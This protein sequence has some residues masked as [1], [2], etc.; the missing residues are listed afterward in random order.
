MKLSFTTLA[1]PNWDLDQILAAA[2]QYG[3][4]AIDFRHYKGSTA[5]ATLPEFTTGLS[6]TAKKIAAAGIRVSGISSGIHVFN[7]DAAKR[8]Q[9]VNEA[10][11]CVRIAAGLGAPLVRVFGG[12]LGPTPRPEA[13]KLGGAT[14]RA[15]A[16]AAAR[17]G[18][19]IA[20]ETHDDWVRGAEVMGILHAANA[21]ASAGVLWDVLNSFQDANEPPEVTLHQIKGHLVGTHWKDSSTLHPAP[22][23]YCLPGHGRAPLRKIHELIRANGYD[24]YYTFEWE[25]AW[26]PELAEADIALPEFVKTMR[27]IEAGK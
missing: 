25:K 7:A 10:I 22:T 5:L 13:L 23:Q 16:A 2:K 3:Y 26:H 12:K 9:A 4:D 20:L 8:E 17:E 21:G 27:A 15:M 18:I 6:D 14:L 19:V 11:A 24:G 1:C